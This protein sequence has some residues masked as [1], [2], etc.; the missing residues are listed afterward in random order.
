MLHGSPLG[1]VRK[2]LPTLIGGGSVIALTSLLVGGVARYWPALVFLIAAFAAAVVV[3]ATPRR[4][5]TA[6][7]EKHLAWLPPA[8]GLATYPYWL[9]VSSPVE[10][11]SSF[12]QVSAQVLPIL[13]LAAVVDIRRSTRL[14]S[15][16][17][18]FPLIAMIIGEIA[19]LSV[20]AGVS[21]AN[22]SSFA[23]VS[24]AFVAGVTAVVLAL[25]ADAIPAPPDD[26]DPGGGMRRRDGPADDNSVEGCR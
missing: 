24:A 7:F 12:F 9:W 15:H 17:L 16:Q 2:A 11:D 14:E 26:A 18:A 8:L 23:T 6:V 5:W 20:S 25:L 3:V 22:A 13:V 19:A 1:N 21:D 10:I 4:R